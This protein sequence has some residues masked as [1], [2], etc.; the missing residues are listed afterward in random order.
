MAPALIA[1]AETAQ[2]VSAALEKFLV[3]V[4]DQS[5]E[6]AALMAL[7]LSTSSALRRL[8]RIIGDFPHHPHYR[9]ISND[10]ATVRQS[11]KF[12]FDD[13]Q[14]LFGG[15]PRVAVLPQGEY[16]YVW[17]DLCDYF[18]AES[19][20]TLCRRMQ[21]YCSLL[22][23]LS[24]ILTEGLPRDPGYF[25]E[26]IIKTEGLLDAQED[27]FAAA[28]DGLDLGAPVEP[29]PPSFE[30]RRPRND[31][32]PAPRPEPFP[33]P[34]RG[35]R[36]N[37]PDLD[38]E[39][40][41]GRDR[42]APPAPEIP[43]SPTSSHTFSSHSSNL[44]SILNSHWL[45]DVFRQSRPATLLEDTGQTSIVHGPPMPGSS[46]RLEENGYI[47]LLELPFEDGDLLVRLY[48]RTGDARARML[49]R[50]IRPER[51]RKEVVL[52]LVSL[53]IERSGPFLKFLDVSVSGRSPKLWACLKFLSYERMVLFYCTCLALRF[54]DIKTPVKKIPDYELHR[55][56]ELFAGRI[57]DDHYEHALRLFKEKDTG[58]IRLQASV[59]TGS[60]KRKPIWTAFITHQILSPT[61][62]SRDSPRVVHLAD[63]QRYIFTEAYNPQKTPSG[64]HELTFIGS[65]DAAEFVKNIKELVKKQT[66]RGRR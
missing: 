22:D 3:P 54:E 55:E 38:V 9:D 14:R 51:Y 36:G 30:R 28:F 27:R 63:L 47:N 56:K 15:L 52:P 33:E 65:A 26:L 34:R 13:V 64:A 66:S 37:R 21:I 61:W 62:L 49:C 4:E 57:V 11:L 39:D 60:L 45:P 31:P 24:D 1:V 12:T 18:R 19:G 59:H 32:R 40:D 44:N 46:A 43:G 58:V 35:D 7:C 20:N 29:R 41:V 48:Q 5:A 53:V 25:E 50:T 16:I 2:D 42:R 6:I 8:D 23:G 17:R 10:L